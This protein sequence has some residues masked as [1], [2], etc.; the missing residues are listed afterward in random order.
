[1]TQYH[2]LD[3][4][5]DPGMSGL[6]SSTGYFALAMV[7]MP[8]SEP[9]PQLAAVRRQLYLASAFEFKYH[10]TRPRQKKVFFE[11]ARST[12]FR[13]RA[14][15]VDKS[16]LEQRFASMSGQEFTVEFISRLALRTYELDLASDILIVDAGTPSLCRAL[17]IRLSSECRQSGRVRPFAKIVGG[18]SQN[19]DGLQLA[20]M[21]AGA[22]RQHVMGAEHEYYETFADKVADLWQVP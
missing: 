18:R 14:V 7:Q 8:M 15:V 1:V 20:D 22:V 12:L 11:A 10:S 16:K 2:F 21:V 6:A 9:L 17:R 19:E 4:S 13:V 3:D 5:G